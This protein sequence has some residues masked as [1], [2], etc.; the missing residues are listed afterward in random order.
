[1]T[2]SEWQ[3]WLQNPVT[4]E[5]FKYLKLRRE[6]VKEEWASSVYVGSFDETVQRNAHA[7][8]EVELLQELYNLEFED[9]LE[10]IDEV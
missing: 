5:W 3:Q 6:K 7:L 1:M 9:V 2:L 8:G 4:K 10:I